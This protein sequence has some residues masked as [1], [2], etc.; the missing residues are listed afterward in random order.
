MQIKVTRNIRPT[1]GFSNSYENR[2][3]VPE[4]TLVES[5]VGNGYSLGGSA[6]KAS[7][8]SKK[9]PISSPLTYLLFNEQSGPAMIDVIKLGQ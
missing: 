3:L 4:L 1:D 6:V 9:Y 5:V 2:N 8:Q 7:G